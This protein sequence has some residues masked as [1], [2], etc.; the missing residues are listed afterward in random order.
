MTRS[1]PVLP[2][3]SV[4]SVDA[5]IYLVGNHCRRFIARSPASE[6]GQRAQHLGQT[7]AQRVPG[8]NGPEEMFYGPEHE[9][10]KEY[11]DQTIAN[12]RGAQRRA[13][14]LENRFVKGESGLI[15]AVEDARGAEGRPGGD[16]GSG[17]E[18]KPETADRLD[19]GE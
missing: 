5:G 7:R 11:A 19:V 9:Q 2:A 12:H 15:A 8:S 17:A 13:K 6:L 18:D 14:A 4:K 3:P 10:P 16:R 1:A